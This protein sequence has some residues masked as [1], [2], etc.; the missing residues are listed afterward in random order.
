MEHLVLG[1]VAGSESTADMRVAPG[2]EPV[3]SLYAVAVDSAMGQ[4]HVAKV[5][6]E[7]NIIELIL[8]V[9]YYT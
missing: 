1:S 6:T 2:S 8:M 4:A 3:L 9:N 5:A 7:V